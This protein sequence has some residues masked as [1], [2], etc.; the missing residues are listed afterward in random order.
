MLSLFF[1][2]FPV[3]IKY[4]QT[5]RM[6]LELEQSPPSLAWSLEPLLCSPT[7]DGG[8]ARRLQNRTITTILLT[9]LIFI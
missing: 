6:S 3:G 7:Y 5:Q 2:F 4:N 1:I 8:A 9:K